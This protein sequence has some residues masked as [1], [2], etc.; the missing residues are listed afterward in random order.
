[1]APLTGIP[2]IERFRVQLSRYPVPRV[3]RQRR[4]NGC[5]DK[6]GMGKCGVREKAVNIKNRTVLHLRASN[7]NATNTEGLNKPRLVLQ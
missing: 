7:A 1:M 2:P 6:R 5:T 4:S 3:L